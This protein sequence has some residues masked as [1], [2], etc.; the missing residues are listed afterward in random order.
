MI[1]FFFLICID[2]SVLEAASVEVCL[3]E[4]IPGTD[5]LSDVEE[6]KGMLQQLSLVVVINS[7]LKI[8]APDKSRFI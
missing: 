5:G 4:Y 2:V 7:R 3:R 8:A 1:V 6:T